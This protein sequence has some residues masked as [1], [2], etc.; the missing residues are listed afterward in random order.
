M[1]TRSALAL[2]YAVDACERA[3]LIG[4]RFGFGNWVTFAT[5]IEAGIAPEWLMGELADAAQ[6]AGFIRRLDGCVV[7]PSGDVVFDPMWLVPLPE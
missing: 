7:T 6:R 4:D 3:S 2:S 1:N 5:M